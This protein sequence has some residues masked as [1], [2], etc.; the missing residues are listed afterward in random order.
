MKGQLAL[1]A[2]VAIAPSVYAQGSTFSGR[3]LTDSGAPIAGAEVVLTAKRGN[4]NSK[5][6]FRLAALQSGE[7]VVLVRMPGY[8]P[9]ADTIDVADA[10]EVRREYRLSRI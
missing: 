4:T 9:R 3:V 2:F 1:L 7:H 5:G 10:G 8:A 6:E